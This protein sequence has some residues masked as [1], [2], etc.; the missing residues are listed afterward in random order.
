MISEINTTVVHK[1]EEDHR[2]HKSENLDQNED[3]PD[4]RPI[5][6]KRRKRRLYINFVKLKY[7]KFLI[8]ENVEKI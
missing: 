7:T 6:D 3:G 1:T 4:H 5:I 2:K 8:Y